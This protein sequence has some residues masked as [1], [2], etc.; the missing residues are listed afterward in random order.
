[1]SVASLILIGG[2]FVGVRAF[3]GGSTR[4]LFVVEGGGLQVIPEKIPAPQLAK[5][6]SPSG[7]DGGVGDDPEEEEVVRHTEKVVTE[8]IAAKAETPN[9]I[10]P[11]STTPASPGS[12]APVIA[13]P[14]AP[15][16]T[17]PKPI[18]KESST[19]RPKVD[20]GTITVVLQG[21]KLQGKPKADPGLALDH[22]DLAKGIFYR[23][24]TKVLIAP[25]SWNSDGKHTVALRES[26][27]L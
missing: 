17:S 11:K 21:G 2:C 19:H 18:A 5:A 16:A 26:E 8:K 24:G 9:T 12:P 6:T 15:T 1:M 4:N 27:V 20:Y 7:L 10:D 25:F 22:I 23:K 3:A 13:P 14:H